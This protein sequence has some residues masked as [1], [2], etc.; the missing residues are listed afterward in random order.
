MLALLSAL[1]A[2]LKAVVDEVE[3]S[4]E[5]SHGEFIARVGKWCGRSVVTATTGVGK[6]LAA[7]TTQWVLDRF[8]PEVIL[9]SGLAGALAP[10]L[11]LGDVVI[12]SDCVYH[13]LDVTPLGFAR[14]LVPYTKHRF[15]ATDERLLSLAVA[16][17]I[18]GAKVRSGR[19][20]TGDQF[21]TNRSSPEACHLFGELSGDVVDMEGASIALV[22]ALNNIPCLIIRTV[23]DRADGSAA[24][25]FLSAL[26]RASENGYQVLRGVVGSL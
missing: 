23:S 6:A 16:T 20:V 10:D 13:D 2:E 15:I 25:S 8:N 1:P 17:T 3:Y 26:E 21:I 11:D 12:A 14:G 19:I 22:A 4:G 9:F 5:I 18:E 24:M 7:A